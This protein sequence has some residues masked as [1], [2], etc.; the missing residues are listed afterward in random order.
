MVLLMEIWSYK[1]ELTMSH[2]LQQFT[3]ITTEDDPLSI[4]DEENVN[5]T[6]CHIE[7]Q[8]RVV[9]WCTF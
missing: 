5:F 9:N 2:D 4:S 8:I 7:Q 6:A 3:Q 1:C